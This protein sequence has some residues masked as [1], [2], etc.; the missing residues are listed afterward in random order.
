M[1]FWGWNEFLDLGPV[2]HVRTKAPINTTGTTNAYSAEC[3]SYRNTYPGKYVYDS[4]VMFQIDPLYCASHDHMIALC[5]LAT[6]LY[7]MC[8]SDILYK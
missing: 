7:M 5:V 2:F 8:N 6:G 3:T 4:W 1:K